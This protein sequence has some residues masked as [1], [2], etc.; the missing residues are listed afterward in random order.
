VLERIVYISAVT[1]EQSEPNVAAILSVS[2]ARNAVQGV[3]GLLIGGG[4]W[5]LQMIEGERSRLE[6]VWQSIR[7]DHRHD[8][9]VL[10]QRRAIRGRSFA[11]WDLQFRWEQDG[12]FLPL[13]EELTGG[14]GDPRLRSQVLR[15]AELF[16]EAPGRHLREAAA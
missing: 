1:E 5:W 3:T 11:G 7:G 14:V 12:R 13:V 8:P 9:V 4:G 6:P 16:L 15:F 10:V 2:R